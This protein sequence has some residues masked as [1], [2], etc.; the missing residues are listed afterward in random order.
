MSIFD[1]TYQAVK[2]TSLDDRKEDQPDT[3]KLWKSGKNILDHMPMNISE[4]EI[5]PL[6]TVGKLA[7]INTK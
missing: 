5:A 1:A 2:C 6:V 3:G 4:A 7:V